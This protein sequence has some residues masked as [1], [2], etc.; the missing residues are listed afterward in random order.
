[1]V[2][3]THKGAVEGLVGCARRTFMVPLP[4]VATWEDFNAWLE[5]HCRKRQGTE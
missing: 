5:D 2:N 3:G 4:R 1:M